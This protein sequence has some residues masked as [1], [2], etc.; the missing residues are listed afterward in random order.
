MV[1]AAADSRAFNSTKLPT[2]G[3]VPL[4]TDSRTRS[5]LVCARGLSICVTRSTNRS[6]RSRTSR[7]STTPESETEYIG[8]ANTT[9]ATHTVFHVAAA[10]PAAKAAII[11]A[12]GNI[13]CR[14]SRNAARQSPVA[15]TAATEAT[16][17]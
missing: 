11:T 14:R 6:V 9:C 16:G 15:A 17:S 13:F 10:K 5:S 3:A 4:R 2:A 8:L 12:I 7:V 1:R